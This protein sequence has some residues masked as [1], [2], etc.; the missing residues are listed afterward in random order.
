MRQAAI[1]ESCGWSKRKCSRGVLLLAAMMLLVPLGGGRSVDAQEPATVPLAKTAG[2]AVVAV[3]G[4]VTITNEELELRLKG[5]LER[6]KNDEYLLKRAVLDELV[7]ERLLAGEAKR[8]NVTVQK[9]LES[10]ADGMSEPSEV[11]LRAIYDASRDRYGSQPEQKAF[12]LIRS[13]LM[14]QRMQRRRSDFVRDLRRSVGV[15]V[16]LDAPR[17]LVSVG[18]VV[19]GPADAPVTLIEFSDFECPYCAQFADTLKRVRTEYRGRIRFAYRH[20][21]LPMHPNAKKAAEVVTC[22]ARQERFWPMHDKLFES[23][24]RVQVGDWDAMAREAGVNVDALTSCLE[25]P[26]ASEAWIADQ[27]VA[28]SLGITGTPALFVNGR[29]FTGAVPYDALSEAIE[30]ELDRQR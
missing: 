7:S 2:R 21:P 10:V 28:E 12:A 14:A 26:D 23:L 13:Q 22:A 3:V 25:S 20:L 9:L 29:L 16:L 6:L 15:D 4:G 19:E 8:R 18:A 1:A 17:M 24:K 11:E 30:E 5:R 27:R